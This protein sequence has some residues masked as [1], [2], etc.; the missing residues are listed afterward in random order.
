MTE[1]T[2]TAALVTSQ[3]KGL[4]PSS[5]YCFFLSKDVLYRLAIVS[6]LPD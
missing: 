2:Q 5:E 6:Q 3:W 1:Q 4:A